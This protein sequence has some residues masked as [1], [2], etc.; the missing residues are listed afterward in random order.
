MAIEKLY[1]DKFKELLKVSDP[2]EVDKR[3]MKIFNKEVYLSTR[4]NKKYMI[5]DDNNRFQHFGD[6][7]FSDFTKHKDEERRNNFKNRN[8][9]WANNENK[10]SPAFLS[11]HLLW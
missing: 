6:I 9:R 5:K 8:K 2:K 3:A 1:D 10:F 7:R 11:Y 4:K